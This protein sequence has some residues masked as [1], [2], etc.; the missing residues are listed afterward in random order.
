[1]PV[2]TNA[3]K[4]DKTFARRI[5]ILP[6]EA[7]AVV[8][9]RR[10]FGYTISALARAFTRSTSSIAK[11][12]RF[13]RDLGGLRFFDLRKIPARIRILVAARQWKTLLKYLELWN[14][15]I[16]AEEGKPP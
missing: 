6:R 10:R 7:A 14:S 5:P 2:L 4:I 8:F 16:L 15:W 12:L 1:M 3:P 11:I 13:N 9:L